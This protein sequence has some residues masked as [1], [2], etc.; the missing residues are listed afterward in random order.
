MGPAPSLP[1]NFRIKEELLP[2]FAKQLLQP[3]VKGQLDAAVALSQSDPEAA[4][5]LLH[6]ALYD[7]AA[8]VFPQASSMSERQPQ[9]AQ[10]GSLRQLPYFDRECH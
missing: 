3:T 10:R 9:R 6:A 1:P 4:A 7:A 8:A 5:S 2:S